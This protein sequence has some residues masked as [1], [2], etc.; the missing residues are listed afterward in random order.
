MKKTLLMIAAALAAGVISTQAQVYSQNVVG[1]YNIT[2]PA[3]GY[4][5]FGNQLVSGS[6]ANQTNNDVN[7]VLSTGFISDSTGV[8]NSLLYVW[9]GSGYGTILTYFNQ[10]DANTYWGV[11]QAG[12]YDGLGT[13][14]TIA[15]KQGVG[16]FVYNGAGI[17]MTNTV[18][19][20][21]PQGTN[22]V[23]ITAGYN[24]YAIYEPVATNIDS[25]LTGFPGTSDST[26]VNNDVYYGWTGSGF[27]TILTYFNQSDANAYWG[28]N[29]AG[30]YDGLGSNQSGNTA[31]WPKVGQ[32]FMIHHIGASVQWTNKFL[33]Q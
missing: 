18:T 19:G 6:D 28:V 7:T 16:A 8:T 12:W 11:N 30:W 14:S 5:F 24:T 22:V 33:I 2:V 21:V 26:G 1:Y 20:T 9:T 13:R 17:P 3:H 25:V 32:G 23:T 27:G 10:S 15:I 29:Q 31:L 4:Y